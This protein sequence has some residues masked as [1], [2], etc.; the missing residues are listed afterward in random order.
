MLSGGTESTA[1]PFLDRGSAGRGCRFDG[2][3]GTGESGEWMTGG[4]VE[5]V[6]VTLKNVILCEAGSLCVLLGDVGRK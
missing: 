5:I 6:S 4:T 2:G 3:R 1:A